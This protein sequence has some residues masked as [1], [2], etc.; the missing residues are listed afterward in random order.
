MPLPREVPRPQHSLCSPRDGWGARGGGSE[1]GANTWLAGALV[2]EPLEKYQCPLRHHKGMI[3]VSEFCPVVPPLR[4]TAATEEGNRGHTLTLGRV[5]GRTS[6]ATA[7]VAAR[8]RRRC[9]KVEETKMCSF[10]FTVRQR[11]F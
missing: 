7:D 9:L 1:G 11:G 3:S 5:A 8:R 10:H 2:T 6:S 4:K